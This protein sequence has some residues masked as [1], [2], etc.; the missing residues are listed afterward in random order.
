[1][2]FTNKDLKYINVYIPHENVRIPAKC[3]EIKPMQYCKIVLFFNNINLGV[4]KVRN[5]IHSAKD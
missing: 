1:M 3:V 2:Y 5:W 4:F